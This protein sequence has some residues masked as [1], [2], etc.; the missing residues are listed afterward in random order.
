MSFSLPGAEAA[1]GTAIQKSLGSRQLV[2]CLSP[3]I[4]L[5]CMR[6]NLPLCPS[7]PKRESDL[8]MGVNKEFSSE[9]F[10]DL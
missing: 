6:G 9:G 8:T 1:L 3:G 5:L 2:F 10:V 7:L 4:F